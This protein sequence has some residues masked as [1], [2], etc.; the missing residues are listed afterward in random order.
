MEIVQPAGEQFTNIVTSVAN[1]DGTLVIFPTTGDV[2]ASLNLSHQN[3]WLTQQDFST[4]IT[5]PTIQAYTGGGLQL[6]DQSGNTIIDIDNANAGAATFGFSAPYFSTITPG[7]A[8]VNSIGQLDSLVGGAS[9]VIAGYDTTDGTPVFFTIGS[10]LT[11]THATHTLSASGLVSSVSN[12]DG[13][14]T[15]SPTTGSVVASRAAISGDISI[16]GGS[17]TATLATVNSNVGSFTYASITVNGKG[18]ITAASSGS[19]PEVPLTFST[20][21]TRTVNTITANISTGVS[22]GQTAIGGTASGNSLTLSSTSNATKGFIIL[23]AAS[24]YDETNKRLGINTTAP[25]KALEVNLGTADAFRLTYNDNNGGATTYNDSTLGSTGI[26]TSTAVGTAAAHKFTDTSSAVTGTYFQIDTNIDGNY[27]FTRVSTNG[28][29]GGYRAGFDFW[30]QTNNGTPIRNF[31][32]VKNSATSTDNPCFF[33]GNWTSGN[34]Q[35]YMGGFNPTIGT[36]SSQTSG[37]RYSLTGTVSTDLAYNLDEG[38]YFA[39]GGIASGNSIEGSFWGTQFAPVGAGY[40]MDAVIQTT[41]ED[42]TITHKMRIKGTSGNVG[43]GMGTS[44]TVSAKLHVLSSS[45]TVPIFRLGNTTTEY[46]DAVIDTSANVTF[47]LTAA[48]GT[49]KFTFSNALKISNLTSGR[50][51]FS[52]TSGELTDDADMTFNTDTLTV[53]K[54]VG[55]TSVKVGSA[56]GYISSD[57]STGATGT[58]TTVDLKTVTV[59]DGIITSIV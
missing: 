40:S 3:N 30:A 35:N 34:M 5:T 41:N 33:V 23:G 29:S 10:G 50:V 59:K 49:P 26:L 56:G 57:G 7:Y 55:S 58:F 14:L 11:Y 8:L 36:L 27:G 17:N 31:V 46:M 38:N 1:T 53:T 54:I 43:I 51:V 6:Q 2:I 19:A 20:G 32:M 44:R 16:A 4:I 9:N 42:R 22:G 47:S 39:L 48:S 18:L 25:D 15:I 21:L 28:K 12:N 37:N 13:T 24:V 45:S 52:T